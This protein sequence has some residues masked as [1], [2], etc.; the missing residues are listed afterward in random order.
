MISILGC[1]WLPLPP[2]LPSSSP[3]MISILGC[4]WLPLPPCPPSFVFQPCLCSLPPLP[5]RLPSLFF[6]NAIWG[7]CRYNLCFCVGW[8]LF[9][10]LFLVIQHVLCL[11]CL[12]VCLFVWLVGWLV[13]CGDWK[14]S[15]G[16]ESEACFGLIVFAMS[17][18]H[19]LECQ[20]SVT[21]GLSP[22]Y[23]SISLYVQVRFPAC[24]RLLALLPI[25]FLF[26]FSLC[27]ASEMLLGLRVV[28]TFV[29]HELVLARGTDVFSGL[30]FSLFP[31]NV[32]V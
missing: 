21:F 1:P 22:C 9:C 11:V 4:S 8:G 32:C 13:G 30:V 6:G 18:G 14:Q 25:F 27:F 26:A 10:L 19:Y 24:L 16:R 17:V 3:F 31:C 15:Q 7:L 5:P 2:C 12:F 23:S 28:S 29:A 20:I